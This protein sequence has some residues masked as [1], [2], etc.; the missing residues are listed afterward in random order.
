MKLGILGKG[1]SSK[2]YKVLTEAMDQIYALKR[3]NLR[4]IDKATKEG[5]KNEVQL[6][7]RLSNCDSIIKLYDFD[8]NEDHMQLV[9][10][11]FNNYHHYQ[12]FQS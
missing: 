1:G 5:Y 7:K 10:F 11:F 4:G 6:L 9:C 8:E 2:V 3:V 12:M